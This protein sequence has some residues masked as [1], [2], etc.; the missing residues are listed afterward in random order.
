MVKFALIL[1]VFAGGFH[2]SF[3]SAAETILLVRIVSKEGSNQLKL[4]VLC[5]GDGIAAYIKFGIILNS[6][7][8]RIDWWFIL[9]ADGL[10]T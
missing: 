9:A 4:H 3:N 10:G 5:I 8:E 7:W 1:I 6:A 2:F